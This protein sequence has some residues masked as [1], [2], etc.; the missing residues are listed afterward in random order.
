MAS[1]RL[2][3]LCIVKRRRY[4]E[5]PE[6]TI[7]ECN[8]VR[9]KYAWNQS[10]KLSNIYT[11]HVMYG[12]QSFKSV[13]HAFQSC[14]RAHFLPELPLDLSQSAIDMKRSNSKKNLVL[15]MRAQH[16]IKIKQANARHSTLLELWKKNTASIMEELLKSKFSLNE[17]LRQLLLSTGDK[18]IYEAKFRAGSVWERQD[19][20]NMGLLGNLLMKIRSLLQ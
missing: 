18:R 11:C 4:Q 19:E 6:L 8:D 17:D 7:D 12:N 3:V 16:K 15:A 9:I 13:E 10:P 1:L 20:E 14:K 2:F 5:M